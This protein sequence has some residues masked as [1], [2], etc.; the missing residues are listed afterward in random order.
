MLQLYSSTGK[1]VL[2]TL[3]LGCTTEPDI[4]CMIIDMPFLKRTGSVTDPTLHYSGTL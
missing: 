2:F 1:L 3:D 4:L